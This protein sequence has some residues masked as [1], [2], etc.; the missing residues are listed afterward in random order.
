MAARTVAALIMSGTFF[1]SGVFYKSII[2]G[3]TRLFSPF[4]LDSSPFTLLFGLA[5][6]RA[7]DRDGMHLGRPSLAFQHP[8]AF[9]QSRACSENIVDQKNA[10]AP[11]LLRPGEFECALDVPQTL[12]A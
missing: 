4:S 5:G 8:C 11:D 7:G 6:Q 2:R 12:P 1:S 9:T 10:A 3:M